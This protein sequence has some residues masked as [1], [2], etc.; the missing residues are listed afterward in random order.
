MTPQVQALKMYLDAVVILIKR[1]YAQAIKRFTALI[2]EPRVSNMPIPC[3]A[4][5][6][7]AYACL[8]NFKAAINDFQTLIKANRA[9]VASLYNHAL[10]AG[11]V[12]VKSTE[13]TQASECFSA[14]HEL[15]EVNSEPLVFLALIAVER[16][17]TDRRPKE[18]I[19]EAIE[20]LSISLSHKRAAE[21]YYIRA[22]LHH[23][24]DDFE[25]SVEDI[26]EVRS[27]QVISRCESSSARHFML[28]GECNA[29]L[30]RLDEA[31]HDYT[32]ATEIETDNAEGYFF[33][34]CCEVQNDDLQSAFNDLQKVIE[35][36]PV[37][38]RQKA[39]WPH[40]KAGHLLMLNQSWPEALKAYANA[41]SL[42]QTY[43]AT[44]NIA[45]CYLHIHD[46]SAAKTALEKCI[47][48][49]PDSVSLES[50]LKAL[51]IFSDLISALSADQADFDGVRRQ[52]TE[53]I[54]VRP[55][56]GLFSERYLHWYKGLAMYFAGQFSK[57][58]TVKLTLGVPARYQSA[59]W[60]FV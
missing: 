39:V 37:K 47:A 7:Y 34:A 17:K 38:S 2:D 43:E 6:A 8:N 4:Y 1:K 23:S 52:L 12:A 49:T 29:L 25:S 50:D 22:V 40:V 16:S 53:L 30:G 20:K 35:N 41:N 57:A 19:L 42:E 32:Y 36:A 5:R 3:E 18:C 31:I 59:L 48:L 15:M 46:L 13:L 51:G 44:Y 26:D 10:C 14:A 11:T 27:P 56:F 58:I 54:C 45:A 33:R 60:A 21:V 55:S 28:R 24:L 9:D